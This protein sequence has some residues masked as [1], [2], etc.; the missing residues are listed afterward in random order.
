[1]RNGAVWLC[2]RLKEWRPCEVKDGSPLP[3]SDRWGKKRTLD[4][5]FVS[6]LILYCCSNGARRSPTSNSSRS[7]SDRADRWS[8][9]R[10]C[11]RPRVLWPS[12]GL[13]IDLD[14][15]RLAVRE[16][17]HDGWPKETTAEILEVTARRTRM[18]KERM[19]REAHDG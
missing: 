17:A 10:V 19:L 1:M 2:K 9:A 15:R 8:S 7:R 5:Y 14:P 6:S 12:D 11:G 13:K 3:D 16:S 18:N 4:T